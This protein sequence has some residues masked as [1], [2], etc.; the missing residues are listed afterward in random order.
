MK[1]KLDENLGRSA[2]D[3]LAGVGHEVATVPE[4]SLGSAA[5]DAVIEAC[6]DE[7][8]ALVT[9]DLDFANPLRFPPERYSGIA[10]LRAPPRISAGIVLALVRT[11]AAALE[12]EQLAGRL[13]IIE[14][15]RVRVHEVSDDA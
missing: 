2:R 10:V 14:V 5:D 8:R 11:L 13:W 6:H 4:Q 9:L 15:G 1:L 7:G 12:K 3:L